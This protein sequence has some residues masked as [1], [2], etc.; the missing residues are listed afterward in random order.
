MSNFPVSVF[1][2]SPH[3]KSLNTTYFCIPK[4]FRFLKVGSTNWILL[5]CSLHKSPLQ[6]TFW[7]TTKQFKCDKN[8]TPISEST[9]KTGNNETGSW[10]GTQPHLVK[11]NQPWTRVNWR[12][13]FVY[14]ARTCIITSAY[15]VLSLEASSLLFPFTQ[16]FCFT[17]G[18]KMREDIPTLSLLVI[19]IRQLLANTNRIRA[20]G[21]W[22]WH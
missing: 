9:R 13:M 14:G 4:D 22:D 19:G 17:V 12:Q 15:V 21:K 20:N 5:G 1:F 3:C 7:L 11:I 10:I 2:R 8:I 18:S 6:H 16:Y